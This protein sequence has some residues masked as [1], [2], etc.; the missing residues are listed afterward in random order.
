MPSPEGWPLVTQP[1]DDLPRFPLKF[2]HA[3]SGDAVKGL[4]SAPSASVHSLPNPDTLSSESTDSLRATARR[5][6]R[7]I[8]H[9]LQ[10]GDQGHSLRAS[11]V[12]YP[13]IHDRDQAFSPLMVACGATLDDCAKNAAKG[14]PNCCHR[15]YGG[16]EAQRPEVAMG[17]ILV[18]P[19]TRAPKEEDGK[20]RIGVHWLPN[21][22]LNCTQ[23]EIFLQIQEKGLLK[24]PNPMR[25][26][27]EERDHGCYCCFHYGYG[28]DTEE[29]YDLKNLIEDLIRRDHLDQFVRKLCEPSLCPKSPVE[30]QID[31]IIG[32]PVTGGNSSSVR[33]AYAHA[34]VQKRPRAWSILIS[35]SNPRVNTQTTM[36]PW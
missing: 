24:N 13:C 21:I 27:A 14:Q 9:S 29:C 11:V 32:G 4:T 17:Q 2:D 7:P 18:G 10:K 16:R 26:Q 33:K 35:L 3:R 19:T 5:A 6:P 28:H 8:P 30:R 23:T 31:V 12:G 36:T 25:T 34:E 22:L 1:V 15:G 20:S